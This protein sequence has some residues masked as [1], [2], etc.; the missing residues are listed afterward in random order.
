MSTS[1]LFGANHRSWSIKSAVAGHAEAYIQEFHL[2]EQVLFDGSA[3]SPTAI[4]TL[5]HSF[6]P[7]PKGE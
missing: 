7:I 4:V 6:Y 1:G 3:R 2:H 5:I